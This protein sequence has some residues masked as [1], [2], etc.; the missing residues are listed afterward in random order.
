MLQPLPAAEE[1]RPDDIHSWLRLT[2]C[3]LLGTIG[4]VGMWAVVVV[5]PGVQADFAVERADASLPYTAAMIGFAAGNVLIGRYV[6]RMGVALPVALAGVA[7]GSGFILS[8]FAQS[9]WQFALL[10]A[11]VGFGA[12][13]TFG[14]LIADIS[15][16]FER[17]RGIAVAAAASGNYLAGV[18][19]PTV[20]KLM[21][22]GTGWRVTFLY[23]GIFCIVTIVPLALLLRPRPPAASP[24]GSD[25]MPTGLRR[26][27]GPSPFSPP[28]LQGLLIVAGVACC[29]AMSM[30]QVH[31]V[32]YC[33]D[34][35]YGVARG[36][37]MLSL[38]L[39]GGIVSR[40]ASGFIADYIGGART[41]LIGSVLQ[42]LALIL[43]IPWDG[44]AS[45]Y[46][47]S[48]VFGLSQGGI[49]PSYAIIVREYLPAREAGQRVGIVIMATIAGMA[50]GGWMSGFIYDLTGSY[51]AA[52]LNGIAWNLLNIAVILLI[53]LR[54]PS[55]APAAA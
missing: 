1:R 24:L 12:S 19:W 22:A 39:A 2:L 41:V 4:S 18:V 45:L 5:L 43:Y 50:L 14:P 49:V 47:V 8:C 48:L 30:P 38:M 51:Q 3:L 52:F 9:V 23:I 13:S 6:D 29:V 37:E 36:A 44:L 26:R 28:V 55:T 7:L 20:I 32:A 54:R 25:G 27:A 10:Q 42:C 40:L 21:L 31:I 46:I 33:V 17:R 53:L 34:L 35:G 11:L 16:W 15:H